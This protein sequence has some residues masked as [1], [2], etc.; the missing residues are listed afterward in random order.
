MNRITVRILFLLLYLG[1]VG[2]FLYPSGASIGE[3]EGLRWLLT[4]GGTLLV[5]LLLFLLLRYRQRRRD[6][7]T[8][9]YYEEEKSKKE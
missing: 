4:M 9:G 3:G 8:Y 5:I 1:A 7:Y 2:Y 6:R